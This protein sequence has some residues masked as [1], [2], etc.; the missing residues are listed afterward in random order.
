MLGSPKKM[1]RNPSASATCCIFEPGSVI[2][3]KR[4]P[5]SAAPTT[6]FT[7]SKKYCLKIFGSSVLPDLL[8]TMKIVFARSI[9][10][11]TAR[12]S[13]GSVESRTCT[14][15][16]PGDLAERQLQ[17]FD[18]QARSAHAQQQHVRESGRA[19][20]LRDGLEARAI[21]NL[22]LGD[23]EPAEPFAFVGVGPKRSIASPEPLHFLAA[24]QSSSVVFTDS[25][26]S[27]GKWYVKFF[28]PAPPPAASRF[29]RRWPA[30]CRKLP[31]KASRLRR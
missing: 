16:K 22:L 2:A 29:F 20:I 17:H 3:M 26:R 24:F 18:A 6:C 27:A 4:F 9:L 12:T 1:W 28:T 15:G 11:S 19:N 5:A 25:A 7:R 14:C 31:R 23:A 21:R 13:A 30:A 10:L 8:D